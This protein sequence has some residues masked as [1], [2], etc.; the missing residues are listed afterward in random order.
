MSKMRAKFCVRNVTQNEG[1]SESLRFTAVTGG[2]PE[3]NT[4]SK[5]TPSATCEMQVTNPA[6]LGQF[7]PGQTFYVD[8]TPADQG[9]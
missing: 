3:D 5:Y 6:L 1:G 7:K 9:A 2:N 4:Y 8:F